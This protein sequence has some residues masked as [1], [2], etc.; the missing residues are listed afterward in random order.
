[1]PDISKRNT[2]VIAIVLAI[3]MLATRGHHVATLTHLPDASWAIFFMLGFYVRNRIL[4]PAFLALAALIDYV[5][6]TW[7]GTNGFCV[8]AAYAFLLLAYSAMWFGGSW[9][10]SRHSSRTSSLALVAAAAVVSTAVCELISSG[11]F[12]FLGGR[13]ADTSLSVFASRLLQFFPSDLASTMMYL[14]L[15]VLIHMLIASMQPSSVAN[16]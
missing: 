11:S 13:F 15:G 12:Y 6:I 9:Y 4:L 10:A 8:T 7:F 2:T 14:G 3:V 5:S 16:Q 1:M